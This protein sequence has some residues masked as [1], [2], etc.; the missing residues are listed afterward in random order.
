MKKRP[1]GCHI[2]DDELSGPW[3]GQISLQTLK[4]I[5]SFGSMHINKMVYALTRGKSR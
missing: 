3:F 2:D 5:S 1:D 4:V